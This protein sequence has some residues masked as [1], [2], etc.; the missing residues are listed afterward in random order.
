MMEDKVCILLKAYERLL[1]IESGE[2]IPQEN[3]V[4]SVLAGTSVAVLVVLT[5]VFALSVWADESYR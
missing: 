1:E 5:I 2:Y 3:S 4:F